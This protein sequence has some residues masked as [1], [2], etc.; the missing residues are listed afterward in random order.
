MK[1]PFGDLKLHYQAYK[2]LIDEGVARVLDSGHFILGPELESFEKEFSQYLGCE[3][4]I[5]CASGTERFISLWRRRALAKVTRF[6]LSRI[7]R[8]TIS[9]I[10]MTGAT[11]VFVDIDPD[12][13]VIDVHDLAGKF[14]AKTKAVMPVH[15]YGM[16]ADMKAILSAAAAHGVPVIEDVARPLVPLLLVSQPERWADWGPSVSTRARI[17][18]L[19]ETAVPFRVIAAMTMKN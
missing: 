12:T 14:T 3:Y 19:S 2:T 4:T 10:S 15:L 17:S 11:P 6:S 7:R 8:T 1:V 9:A 16:V 13:Y 18:A 5:G